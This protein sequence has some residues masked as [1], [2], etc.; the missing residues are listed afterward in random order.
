[1]STYTQTVTKLQEALSNLEDKIVLTS[2]KRIT[3]REYAISEIRYYKKLIESYFD[4]P[5]D[6]QNNI[7]IDLTETLEVIEQWINE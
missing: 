4:Y 6:L 7:V 3:D 2:D 1:M 5:S